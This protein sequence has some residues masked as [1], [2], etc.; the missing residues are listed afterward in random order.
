MRQVG[1]GADAVGPRRLTTTQVYAGAA[2]RRHMRAPSLD[3]GENTNAQ[4]Y[5]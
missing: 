4:S 3:N 5:A 1:T 2:K